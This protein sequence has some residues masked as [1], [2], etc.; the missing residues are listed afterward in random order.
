MKTIILVGGMGTRLREVVKDVPK[1]MA[2]INGKPFLAYLMENMVH[3]GCEEFILCVGY[4]R[5]IIM[6]YFKDN[7]MGVPVKYS[8]EEELLGTGGAI[9]QAFELFD[10]DRAIILNG[11][12]FVKMDYAEFEKQMRDEELGLSLKYVPNASRY[13]LVTTEGDRVV[14]FAEKRDTEEAGFI[15]A[16]IYAVSKPL[17]RFADNKKFSFEKD[18]LEKFVAEIK[19]KYFRAEDYFIDI[20]IP[21][22]YKQA[23]AE[24][25]SEIC[26]GK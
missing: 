21:E 17:F 22:S 3:F 24:L 14:E 1:P 6:D 10:V 18:I 16:G 26:N 13:G 15:N 23:C 8:V 25:E 20:G 4:K 19:P 2:D 7:F 5:E 12:T 11:D 9:K